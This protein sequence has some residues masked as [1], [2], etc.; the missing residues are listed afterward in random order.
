MN[1]FDRGVAW[2]CARIIE[3]H[4]QPVIAG[5]VLRESGVNL[6]EVKTI[7]PYDAE[8]LEKADR[9]ELEHRH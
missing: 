1:E 4:D 5:D 7:D 9:S 6:E 2:A 8:F 3:L